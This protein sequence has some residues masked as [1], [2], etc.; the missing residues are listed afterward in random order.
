MPKIVKTPTLLGCSL[1][2]CVHVAGVAN[3]FRIAEN[4]GFRT[5]LLGAAIS[6]DTL[7]DRIQE[8]APDAVC[9]SY[10]LTAENCGRL[11][12]SF[13]SAIEKI[14]YNGKLLFGGTPD[15]VKVAAEF[16]IFDCYFVGEE[17]IERIYAVLDWLRGADLPEEK[18]LRKMERVP[19]QNALDNLPILNEQGMR[20]PLLRHHFGLPS[21]KD[22][23]EGI[24]TISDAEVIDVISIA[25][26]QNA[27]EFFFR[28]E[29]RDPE[30]DGS[31]GTPIRSENHLIKISDARRRG[32][33]PY[34]RIYSGTQDLLKWA[35]MSV[36]T[37]DNAWGTIP[38]CW[39]SRLDGRSRRPL[40]EAIEENLSVI[41]WYGGIG[42]PVEINESH[43]WSLRDAPDSVAVAMS[44]IAAYM[45][46]KSGVRRYIAQYMFNNP[47]FTSIPHDLA[48]IAVKNILVQ[49]LEN[50]D[51]KVYR[52][53]RAGLAHFSVDTDVAKGQLGIAT[54]IMMALHP[55]ILHIVGFTEA[56]HAARA[57]EAI[58]SAKIVRGVVRNLSMGLPNLFADPAVKRKA[59]ILLD[60]SRV[61]L[62]AV[63]MLGESM[64]SE[65][66]IGDPKVLAAAVSSGIFD[67]PHLKGQPDALGEV[68]TLPVNGGCCA[69]DLQGRALDERKRLEEPA[70]RLKLDL[71]GIDR[72][73]PINDNPLTE[74]REE[75]EFIPY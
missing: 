68:K 17:S 5:I 10:R 38:L 64:G 20:M 36:R 19:L 57:D 1:G 12:S 7:V 59:E 9:V 62:A 16:N 50:E 72:F 52:Q 73:D 51:F 35:E 71:K 55:H 15:T 67:A 48:K 58:E 47:S 41:K 42:K 21:M 49:S 40:L 74:N 66:P 65:D 60:E 4:Y 37:I 25:P 29:Q 70:R 2:N 39:Y 43:Q 34:L 45:A 26:D 69:V 23:V 22:T 75:I 8:V 28:P 24:K 27:Q 44:F 46:R 31:G 61:L 3:F 14:G 33:Y 53:V 63:R 32:N 56:D 30:L 18:S 6:T 13:K 11:M 54:A